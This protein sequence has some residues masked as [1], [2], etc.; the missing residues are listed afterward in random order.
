MFISCRSGLD[1]V[2]IISCPDVT[3]TDVG[4]ALTRTTRFVS[5]MLTAAYSCRKHLQ[6]RI[7]TGQ[8]S[9]N[10]C[11]LLVGLVWIRLIV[12]K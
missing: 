2:K 10:M 3:V 4:H 1:Y 6:N 12:R 8:S 5:Q 11:S 7:C 9:G